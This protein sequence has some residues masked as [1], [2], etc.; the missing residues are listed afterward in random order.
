[1]IVVR[2][3]FAKNQCNYV[4]HI[5]SEMSEMSIDS[6]SIRDNTSVEGVIIETRNLSKIRDFPQYQFIL[7]RYPHYIR[8]YIDPEVIN[9]YHEILHD[10]LESTIKFNNDLSSSNCIINVVNIND[11]IKQFG[12]LTAI[13]HLS[14]IASR[15]T[16]QNWEF[17][18]ID[19]NQFAI[20]QI[21]EKLNKPVRIFPENSYSTSLLGRDSHSWDNINIHDIP[22]SKFEY[23]VYE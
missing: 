10:N 3:I 15:L 16:S 12:V 8:H 2:D 13:K 20:D 5:L 7:D 14:S 18:N 21:F 23:S 22:M 6:L 11:W 19:S 9:T 4:S 17:V 1:M